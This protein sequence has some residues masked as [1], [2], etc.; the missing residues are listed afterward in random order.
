MPIDSQWLAIDFEGDTVREAVIV[1]CW[2]KASLLK[3]H[4]FMA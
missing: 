1:M 2:A 4:G 3:L